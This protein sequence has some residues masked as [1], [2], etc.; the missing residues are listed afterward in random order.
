MLQP[1]RG[2][3]D[4]LP[5]EFIVHD[6]IINQAKKVGQLYGYLQ[7]DIPIMEYSKIFDRTLGE[8]SDV[9]SKEMYSFLD[10]SNNS[11]SLRPEFTAGII[12]AFISNGLHHYLPIKFFSHGPVFRY[13]RPMAARQ[14][15]F[16]QLN[17]E[18][19]GVLSP[20]SD[21]ETIK[22]ACDI[23]KAL[24]IEDYVVL[25]INSL[26]CPESRA[27]YQ[28]KLVEYFNKHKN[29]LS[30]DSLRRL[31]KNPMRILDSK[32]ENDKII[33]SEAPLIEEYYSIAAKKYF[34]ELL[35][36][37]ELVNI[38][39]LINP[40]LV[41][42][43]DYY[44]HTAFEFVSPML[45]SQSTVIAGGRYDGLCKLMGGVD[46]PAIGFASGIER[47]ALIRDYHIL[48]TR[49]IFLLPISET[50]NEYCFILADKLRQAGVPIILD[51]QG[52]IGRRIQRANRDKARYVIFV[53]EEEQENAQFKI[54]DLDQSQ[55]HILD[56]AALIE[57]LKSK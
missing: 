23:I 28:A 50:N 2:T 20:Y 9:I 6:Y 37:L 46:T 43:L 32:D 25:E 48:L 39:Y 10:K 51:M 7:M 12:R 53:G 54:K 21:A 47:L 29:K 26:G 14:R 16:H 3:K 4:L 11:I 55:E 22:L 38:K 44:C 49:P 45:G 17:F 52:K 41:R 31:E 24:E 33:V 27:A 5:Q 18:Y 36:L 8:T 57:F 40:R 34:D 1:L 30:Q 56:F 42:G 15:Q 13:D 19:V 35:H